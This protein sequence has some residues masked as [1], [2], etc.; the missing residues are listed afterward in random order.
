MIPLD[1][2]FYA[3][4]IAHRGLHDRAAGI[5]ENSLSAIELAIASGYGIE[6]DIQPSADGQA[7]V[8][9][10]YAM[11][12][13]LGINGPISSKTAAELG[14][15]LLIDSTDT[16]PTLSEVLAQVAGR[17]PALIE[18]KDQDGQLGPGV[19]AL[20]KAV[21]DA[22]RGYEGAVALMSF[23]PNSTRV[24]AEHCPGLP[25]GLVTDPFRKEDWPLV[26]A[27]RRAR[28]AMIPDLHAS[29]ASFISHN[30]AYLNSAP[31]AAVKARGMPVLC[32]T[33]RSAEQ[34]QDA[35]RIANQITFEGFRP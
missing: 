31:V 25:R 1:P 17:A 20:E 34:A 7:M 9:H 32:W 10:D 19:G 26:P 14:E 2:S 3:R 35:Y 13:L 5:I 28:L 18:I 21:G 6:I 22:L 8:F 4:P 16:V 15:L 27:A 23:N 12:R 29:S 30:R 33:V 11:D 24:L